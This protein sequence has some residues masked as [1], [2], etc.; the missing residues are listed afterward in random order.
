LIALGGSGVG[1]SSILTRFAFDKF[2][3]F[4]ESTL[5]AAFIPKK[6]QLRDG[7]NIEFHVILVLYL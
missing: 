1:K 6:F 5:G 7:T 3:E 4:S 2:D